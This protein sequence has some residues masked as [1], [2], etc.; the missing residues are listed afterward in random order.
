MRNQISGQNGEDVALEY[1]RQ[2]GY[3]ILGRNYRKR[4][5]EIDLI[6]FDPT[7]KELTFIEVKL[8]KNLVFGTPE[9]SITAKKWQ[10]IIKTAQWWLNEKKR[11]ETR[12]RV[13]LIAIEY[14]NDKININHIQNIS[15]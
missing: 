4:C 11:A 12:W 14:I 7:N 6:A 8:R 5:G 9:E 1:L 10:R 13:D 3:T 2:K 15:L